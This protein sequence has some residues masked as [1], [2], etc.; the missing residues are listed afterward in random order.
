MTQSRAEKIAGTIR[1]EILQGRLEPGQRLPSER[2]LAALHQTHRSVVREALKK[3]EQLRLVEIRRGGGARVSPLD[4]AS[5]DIVGHMLE[6]NDLPDPVLVEQL[7]DVI[8]SQM[9]GAVRFAVER[10]SDAELARG[11]ELLAAIADPSNGDDDYLAAHDE[12]VRLLA[13]ASRNL[14]L[15]I[16]R[17]SLRPRFITRLR[18]GEG[19]IRPPRSTLI[20]LAAGL[21]RALAERDPIA[22]EEEVRSLLRLHREMLLKALERE[23]T[24]QTPSQGEL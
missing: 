6:M 2:D 14:V 3:L 8:E 24:R 16:I 5:L 13:T 10:G 18:D 1:D 21:D 17:R 20:P 15:E 4:G 19:R 9:T 23:L 12:L 22:A 7:L 11:R